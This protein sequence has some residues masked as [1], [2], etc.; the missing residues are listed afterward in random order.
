VCVCVC[1]ADVN[2]HIKWNYYILCTHSIII[3]YCV[4]SSFV[5]VRPLFIL[6]FF[7]SLLKTI[8]LFESVFSTVFST[9]TFICVNAM[10]T[11]R[12]THH[13]CSGAYTVWSDSLPSTVFFHCCKYLCQEAR[14][15]KK[16]YSII[17]TFMIK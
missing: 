16:F 15:L 2:E 4:T 10:T 13:I 9:R 11:R 7:S 8:L 14:K 17:S 12:P 3:L 5:A 1:P 6:H